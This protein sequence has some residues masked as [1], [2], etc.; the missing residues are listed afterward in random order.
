MVWIKPRTDAYDH[1]LLD[2]VRGDFMLNTNR[3][4][5][6]EAGFSGV[7]INSNGFTVDESV[8]GTTDQ[9]VNRSNSTYVA[10]CWKAADTTTTIAANTVGNTIASDVRANPDAGFSIVKWAGNNT[11]GATIG[12]GLSSAPEMIIIKNY[13][14]PIAQRWVIGH[15]NMDSSSPWNYYLEFDTDAR[16]INNA[17][18]FNGTAPT[19]SVF[20]VGNDSQ[21]NADDM[22]AYCFHSV[23]GYQKM[24][25]YTGTSAA[26]HFI[27]TGFSPRFLMTKRSSAA[28]GGW[29]IFD[30]TRTTNKR[31]FPHDAAA[32]ATD[33]T[34]IVT[35]NS[36]GFTFNTADSWNNNSLYSYIY[37]AIA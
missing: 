24:G 29:N 35:F 5:A 12:H 31:L 2:S 10:W 26:G 6:Q 30:S 1:N 8:T 9:E 4:S 36:N 19:S 15:N 21:V 20:S 25:S 3:T 27:E 37:L 11:A 16:A 17:R 28:G 18:S 13:S 34:E 32:E 33:G 23:D 7:V 14:Q 22:I